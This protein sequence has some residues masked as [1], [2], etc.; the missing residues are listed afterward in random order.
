[1]AQI[2]VQNISG[3]E[4]E[5]SD[6]EA[7]LLGLEATVRVSFE[8][9]ESA[10]LDATAPEWSTF[11]NVLQRLH[12]AGVLVYVELDDAGRIIADVQ[13]PVT[14]RV[15]GLSETPAGDLNVSLQGHAA[16]FIVRR[17]NVRFGDFAAA[18]RDAFSRGQAVSLTEHH[19]SKEIK[20][21]RLAPNPPAPTSLTTFDEASATGA[22]AL[23]AMTMEEATD[24]F[25]LASE[26][27]CDPGLEIPPCIPFLYPRRGCQG[28]A[29]A[30][31][32]L[33]S[34]GGQQAGK[35][36]NFGDLVVSTPNEPDCEATWVFHVAALVQAEPE[37]GG[38]PEPYVIDPA[39]FL[40]P[41]PLEDW[42]AVQGDAEAKHVITSAVPFVPQ[43]TDPQG[44]F[45]NDPNG[46]QMRAV[47]EECRAA[48]RRRC[49]RNGPPPPPYARCEA[50]D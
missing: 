7:P 43:S 38:R 36:W 35:V 47:L 50:H 14:G 34:G 18:L 19:E 15:Q 2:I 1:M 49:G 6:A 44:G 12:R 5:L 25:R 16:R 40:K 41:V 4:P 23:Q 28:R 8:N 10:E 13:I 11:A 31:C 17:A 29:A 39:L 9:G 42:L 33:F 3:F 45:A 20:D 30:M 37:D 27:S 21:I 32:R 26:R 22:T 48:L 24:L 46:A